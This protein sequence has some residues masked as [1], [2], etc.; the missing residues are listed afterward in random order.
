MRVRPRCC[1]PTPLPL[2]RGLFQFDDEGMGVCGP[3]IFGGMRFGR[4]PQG[5][6]SLQYDLYHFAFR[7]AEL[8]LAI[9]E[10]VDHV[11]RMGVQRDF[12]ARFEAHLKDRTRSFS[13]SSL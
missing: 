2:V 13:N 1:P 9:A 4:N 8:Q 6:A 11:V 7:G 5:L 3:D 10:H 12:L